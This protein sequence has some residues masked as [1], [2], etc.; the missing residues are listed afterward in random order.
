MRDA[1]L[2]EAAG[3]S[4]N[5]AL[6]ENLLE[7]CVDLIPLE[8]AI[9]TQPAIGR[10]GHNTEQDDLGTPSILREAKGVFDD[11][12]GPLRAIDHGKHSEGAQVRRSPLN[13][14]TL[15]VRRELPGVGHGA[16]GRAQC[17]RAGA[18]G[19]PH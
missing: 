4:R 16:D 11:T 9:A 13:G 6:A 2:V 10:L 7:T 3:G 14:G 8:R 5:G 15:L 12:A 19:A 17:R 18:Q 1:P